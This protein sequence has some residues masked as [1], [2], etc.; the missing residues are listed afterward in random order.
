[1]A[2]EDKLV[3]G[4]LDDLRG[5]RRVTI[6]LIATLQGGDWKKIGAVQSTCGL[7]AQNEMGVKNRGRVKKQKVDEGGRGGKWGNSAIDGNMD[8]RRKGTVMRGQLS[9]IRGGAASP[10]L[11]MRQPKAW[12][13]WRIHH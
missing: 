10:T 8:D 4:S 1:M 3:A 9:G 12:R 13:G 6:R 11:E 2:K 5:G 7:R